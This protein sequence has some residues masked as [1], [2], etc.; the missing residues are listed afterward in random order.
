MKKNSRQKLELRRKKN[1]YVSGQP[2]TMLFE[3]DMERAGPWVKQLDKDCFYPG[4]T[5]YKDVT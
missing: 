5:Q 4:M 1:T 2:W 3:E